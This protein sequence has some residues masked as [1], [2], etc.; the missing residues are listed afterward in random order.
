MMRKNT[1]R[2]GLPHENM[3]QVS[4]EHL[5]KSMH[6]I[7]PLE[8]YAKIWQMRH[9]PLLTYYR[10]LQLKVYE[11]IWKMT[12]IDSLVEDSHVHRL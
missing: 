8:I 3:L 11:N 2:F 4:A 12:A 6:Y 5:D 9:Y 1:A 7:T 10:T